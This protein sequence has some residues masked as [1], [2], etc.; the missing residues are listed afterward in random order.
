MKDNMDELLRKALKPDIQPDPEL[1]DR[2]LNEK[3]IIEMTPNRFLPV[4]VAAALAGAVFFP[5]P[6][7]DDKEAE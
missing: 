3:R 4:A 2:I 7:A 5:V 6:S 1:N